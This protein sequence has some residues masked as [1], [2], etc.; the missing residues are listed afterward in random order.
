M[1]EPEHRGVAVIDQRRKSPDALQQRPLAQLPQQHG[2]D[3]T[4]LP[5]VDYRDGDFGRF[6]VIDSSHETRD[7]HAT[8]IGG[9]QRDECLVI[10]MV[11][12]CEI[13]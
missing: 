10:V 12:V 4:S 7:T 2:A 13:S 8:T 3:T 9:V 6:V 11:D 1:Q 5:V